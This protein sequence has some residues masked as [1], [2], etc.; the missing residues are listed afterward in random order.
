MARKASLSCLRYVDFMSRALARA[1]APAAAFG[2]ALRGALRE[3]HVALGLTA[4]LVLGVELVHQ[5]WTADLPIL[6]EAAIASAGILYAWRVQDELRVVPLLGLTLAF[7]VGWVLLHLAVGA[8]ADVD[9]TVVYRLQG[10]ALL[11]GDYPRS[12][13]PVGAVLLFAFEAWVG[14]GATRT[15]NAFAMIPFQLLTVA[16]VFAIRTRYSAWLA[17]LVALWPLNAFYW[18]FKFDL[19]PTALLALGLLLALRE[20]WGWSG[21]VL[22]LGAAVKWVP[23]L[24]FVV[25][26]ASLIASGRRGAARAHALT[27]ALVVLVLHLPFLVWSPSDVLAAYERQGGREITPESL[28]YLFLHPVGLAELRTHISFSAGAPEW[29]D[30]AAAAIQALLVLVVVLAAV[31]VR[32]NARAAVALA[33]VAPVVFLL[34][35]RIFSPQFMVLVLVA[36]SIGA[37]LVSPTRRTQLAFGVALM[38]ATLANGFVYPYSL[39]YQAIT[40]QIASAVLFGLAFAVTI[41]VVRLSLDARNGG[42]GALELGLDRPAR[43]R[44]EPGSGMDQPACASCRRSSGESERLSA[45]RFSTAVPPVVHVTP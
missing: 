33:A 25:L 30:V 8:Q 9:S 11:D 16:C 17:A 42:Q 13:Y 1:G 6:L 10:N 34:T 43:W 29:A 26:V 7:H 21:A 18:E 23:G 37:A 24:A 41:G 35:N 32:G 5:T 22:G 20:R 28:W 4:T 36:L 15:A 44:S 27:F 39:P 31:R 19:V 3:P 45:P 38:G 12:E 2:D 14:G 40:W